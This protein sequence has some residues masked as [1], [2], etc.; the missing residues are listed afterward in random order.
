MWG[1]GKKGTLGIVQ[2][3]SERIRGGGLGDRGKVLNQVG[4]FGA[5]RRGEGRRG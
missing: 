4:F 2:Y 5:K 1:W 3:S